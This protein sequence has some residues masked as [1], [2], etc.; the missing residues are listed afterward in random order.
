MRRAHRD[1]L[2]IQTTLISLDRH[3]YGDDVAAF[4]AYVR[5]YIRSQVDPLLSSKK[6]GWH[7]ELVSLDANL[8]FAKGAVLAELGD[9]R[10]VDRVIQSIESRF[11]GLDSL[12]VEFPLDNPTTLKS[13]L[14]SLR[15]RRWSW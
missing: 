5:P 4:E 10:S 8:L 9:G 14:N 15:E 12:L 2:H 7:P 3:R 6:S 11:S 13:G 1:L